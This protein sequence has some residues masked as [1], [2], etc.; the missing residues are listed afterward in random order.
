MYD[1]SC[2]HDSNGGHHQVFVTTQHCVDHS[3]PANDCHPD[4][5]PRPQGL[6]LPVFYWPNLGSV[7]LSLTSMSHEENKT[8]ASWVFS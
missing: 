4:A 8:E 2:S 3:S 7:N 5:N 6:S 1:V